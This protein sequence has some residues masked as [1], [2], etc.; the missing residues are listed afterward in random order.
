MT[1]LLSGMPNVSAGL[2]GI[3][4][5]NNTAPFENQSNA[6]SEEYSNFF[7][8]AYAVDVANFANMAF[9]CEPGFSFVA[10]LLN[11]LVIPTS[12]TLG[13]ESNFWVIR[14]CAQFI[15]NSVEPI[16]KLVAAVSVVAL[17]YFG[18]IVMGSAIMSI[19]TIKYFAAKDVLPAPVKKIND[20]LLQAGWFSM[21]CLS[22]TTTGALK[23]ISLAILVIT[24][25]GYIRNQFFKPSSEASPQG[26]QLQSVDS[27]EEESHS[28]LTTR[29]ILQIDPVQLDIATE[30]ARANLFQ[31]GF[32]CASLS[33]ID[34]RIMDIAYYFNHTSFRAFGISSE[35]IR[36]TLD[37][38]IR[39]YRSDLTDDEIN[40]QF[41]IMHSLGDTGLIRKLLQAPIESVLVSYLP[42]FKPTKQFSNDEEPCPKFTG[43]F[44]IDERSMALITEEQ[45]KVIITMGCKDWSPLSPLYIRTISVA[46]LMLEILQVPDI[47]EKMRGVVLKSII[48]TIAKILT[49]EQIDLYFAG[50][51]RPG[52]LSGTE[53]LIRATVKCGQL[54]RF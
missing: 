11:I 25:V 19:W 9:R 8:A 52:V 26:N 5:A 2:M 7:K 44:R 17:L 54:T 29:P 4:W 10:T 21:V 45:R 36:S 3:C 40:Q 18:N 39:S 33:S 30:E 13:R 23:F 31:N 48:N 46:F 20:H 50:A 14:N 49:E 22:L 35:K 51:N 16:S 38:L 12:V 47:Q 15:E 24:A 53:K 43:A 42:E 34:V 28:F 32:D 1:A 6:S 27:Q 37:S 41:C